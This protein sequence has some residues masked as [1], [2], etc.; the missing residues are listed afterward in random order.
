MKSTCLIGAVLAAMLPLIAAADE[1][2][3]KFWTRNQQ[4]STAPHQVRA[5]R[6]EDEMLVVV[7]DP[8][9]C[10]QTIGNP[11]YSIERNELVVRYELGTAPASPG[12]PGSSACVAHSVFKIEHVPDRDLKVRFAGGSEAF[13]EARLKRCPSQAPRYDQWDCLVPA[14]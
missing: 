10:G 5:Y 11:Q 1:P 14:Q 8:V 9:V 3:M 7:H 4:P 6:I 2:E 13:T 12:A